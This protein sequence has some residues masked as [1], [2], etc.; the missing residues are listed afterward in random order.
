MKV[1]GVLPAVGSVV[2]HLGDGAC[3]EVVL[4][5]SPLLGNRPWGSIPSFTQ[6]VFI[7]CLLCDKSCVR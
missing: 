3:R 6:Q 1:N 7:E 2:P 5:D 4:C